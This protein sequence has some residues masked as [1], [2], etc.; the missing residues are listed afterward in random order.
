[1]KTLKDSTNLDICPDG[2]K[3]VYNPATMTL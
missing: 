2:A 3:I 1:M